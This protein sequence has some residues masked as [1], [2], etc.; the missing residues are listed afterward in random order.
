MHFAAVLRRPANPVFA[1]AQIAAIAIP[2]AVVNG[3]EDFVASMG[4]RLV[5]AL[6]VTQLLL[7]GVGHFDLTGQ[8]AFR[9]RAVQ[10]LAH[11]DPLRT[12]TR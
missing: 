9:D 7:P 8:I 5:D 1:E 6:G 11:A 2:V 12:P 3:A 10:F 4:T